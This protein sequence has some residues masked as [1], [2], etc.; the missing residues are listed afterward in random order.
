MKRKIILSFL[1]LI[2]AL[3][4]PTS[5]SS[6][7]SGSLQFPK[8]NYTVETTTVT[9]S[10]GTKT[11]TYHSY[12]DITYVANPVDANYESMNV[13]VPVNI[14]GVDIDATNAP[15]LFNINVGGY[16]SSTA[17]GGGS[18]PGGGA[19]GGSSNADLALAAG[20]VVVSPG[21][22]GRD[23]VSSNGTYYG[24]APAAIVD[25]KSAV[26]DIRY[27]AGSFPGNVNW[28]ISCG[29]SAG[30]AL[31]ALL[32]ASG[33]SDLY[34]AYFEE[35]GAADANDNIYASACYCPITDLDHADMAY[36]WEFG[37]VALSS[38]LVDQIRSQELKNAFTDYQVALNLTGKNDF[39]TI[40]A[41][42]YADYL[43][44]TYLVPSAN[45]YL[46]ALTDTDRASYL[47]NNKWI[48][49]ANNTASFTFADYLAHVGRMKSLPA[50]DAFDLSTAECILFGDL[51]TNARHFTDFSQRYTSGNNS[52]EIDDDLKT[53]VNLMNPMYFIGQKNGGCANYWWIRHGTHDND[54]SL[55]VIINMATSLEDLN[56][57][58]NTWLYWDAGHGA[59]EDPEDFIAWIG[60]IT[61]YTE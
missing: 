60:S 39:G 35:L 25:L 28:I 36:E 51:N 7:K 2:V 10:Q 20:Y 61:G 3:S 46:S 19:P 9:T 33:N 29:S 17:A 54:T 53:A 30:G 8:D 34:D 21:C 59:N 4:M 16:M 11:V 47:A 45:K 24:K 18:L 5:C 49:W 23:N 31:S 41:A 27:N 13:N 48:T 43:L 32:G 37:T 42:N 56:K 52:A 44:Q 22:R 12:K 6:S 40:T 57:N 14:D 38:G 55:P 1:I 50:F 26:R 58:V 15:I